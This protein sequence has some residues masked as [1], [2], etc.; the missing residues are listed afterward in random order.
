[1]YSIAR[2]HLSSDR[3]LSLLEV[4]IS[5]VVLAIGIL[6]LAPMIVL[7]IEGNTIS[8]DY[9]IASELAKEQLEFYEGYGELMPYDAGATD[10]LDMVTAALDEVVGYIEIDGYTG[11]VFIEA[12]DTLNPPCLCK[13][14]VNITWTTERG[15]VRSTTHSTLMVNN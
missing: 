8:R 2:R 14:K 13:V 7:S 10:S 3:G 11:Q 12:A 1:M 4:L 15:Q 6:G 5:M 9:S